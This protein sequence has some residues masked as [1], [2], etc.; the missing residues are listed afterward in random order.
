MKL[1]MYNHNIIPLPGNQV[2][3]IKNLVRYKMAL[4]ENFH[5]TNE[6]DCDNINSEVS[7]D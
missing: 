3:R 6:N 2:I 7:E 5:L 4:P 1:V